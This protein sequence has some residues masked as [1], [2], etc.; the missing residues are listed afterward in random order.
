MYRLALRLVQ[1]IHRALICI[2]DRGAKTEWIRDDDGNRNR[3]HE[4]HEEPI[5]HEVLTA[6]VPDELLREL[7]HVV[8]PSLLVVQ[9]TLPRIDGGL[10]A[11]DVER[12]PKAIGRS[13]SLEE[14]M[15]RAGFDPPRVISG[16]F[17][18]KSICCLW[19]S[20]QY[21]FVEA[22]RIPQR[23]ENVHPKCPKNKRIGGFAPFDWGN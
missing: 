12:Y 16:K 10:S 17:Q 20:W 22:F 14:N 21:E 23:V 19:P 6:L 18:A 5:L 11:G 13:G 1:C 4:R 3:R 8:Q 9:L 15:E 7:Q 2:L